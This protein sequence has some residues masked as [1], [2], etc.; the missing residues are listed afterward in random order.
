M[1]TS[2]PPS[3]R[4]R[5]REAAWA[6]VEQ[7][8]PAPVL[9]YA[10]A[11][12]EWMLASV[13]AGFWEWREQGRVP[14]PVVDEL[15]AVGGEVAQQV[16]WALIDEVLICFTETLVTDAIEHGWGEPGWVARGAQTVGNHFYDGYWVFDGRNGYEQALRFGRMAER[17]PSPVFLADGAGRIV[18]ANEALGRLLSVDAEAMVGR[19]LQA[20]FGD[21]LLLEDGV[22]CDLVL[23]G[24]GDQPRYVRVT[25]LM[26]PGEQEFEYFGALQDRTHEVT[27]E[28]TRDQVVA[29]ISHELRTPLTAVLG[30]TELLLAGE[31]AG[32]SDDERFAAL[33]TMHAE[34][35]LLLRLV[36]DLVDYAH[37]ETG[38]IEAEP[39]VFLLADAVQAAIR[40][41][42][43][44]GD[45]PQPEVTITPE[46]KV[47]ADR[48]RLEQVF[49]NLLTNAQRYGGEQVHVEA[50]SEEDVVVVRFSDDGPGVPADRRER[51]FETFYRAHDDIGVGAGIGLAVCRAVVRAH[52][53]TIS[54][55]DR[56]GASF[57]IELPGA[58]V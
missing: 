14:E 45:E 7:R 33:R 8:L 6:R 11:A 10:H 12:I 24:G 26:I 47:R 48:R 56:P 1:E 30:Y 51:I 27:L 23:D 46:F 19:E 41:T 28:V 58:I 36:H 21:E 37:L 20:L 3:T 38:R 31:A 5:V 15:Q 18:F 25:V 44:H 35:E 22:A 55:E 29:T 39:S 4:D 53:G 2:P 42:H 13:L 54:L 49:T 57:R 9:V 50:W 43:L 52:G 17:L 32:I 16:A 34:A 40:R